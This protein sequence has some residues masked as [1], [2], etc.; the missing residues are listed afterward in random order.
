MDKHHLKAF[1]ISLCYRQII[2]SCHSK[3]LVWPT[4]KA[5][6]LAQVNDWPALKAV[7]ALP[8]TGHLSRVTIWSRITTSTFVTPPTVKALV[9]KKPRTI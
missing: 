2:N 6:S 1:K 9:T 7:L 4:D 5:N 3:H 8:R